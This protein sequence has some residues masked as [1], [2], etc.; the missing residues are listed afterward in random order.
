[1][2]KK[3]IDKVSRFGQHFMIDPDMIDTIVEFADIKDTE[4]VIE[5]GT[6]TGI[7]TEAIAKTGCALTSYEID[8]TLEEHHNHL[9]EKYKNITIVYE[10]ALKIELPEFD[11]IVANIPYNISEPLILKLSKC[12]FKEGILTVNKSFAE[13]M[14]NMERESSLLSLFTPA[15]FDV[16]FLEIVPKSSFEPRPRI[17][18]AIIN[19]KPIKKENISENDKRL[20]ITRNLFDQRTKKTENALL[21]A[22]IDYKTLVDKKRYTQNES[23]EF[24]N[25][26]EID[27]KTLEKKVIMLSYEELSTLLDKL[28]EK[29]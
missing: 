7:L 9:K 12:D 18:S 6:G 13:K 8:T 15:Y 28:E 5:I 27:D 19:I 14:L 1:M 10:N 25:T 20:F 11:K 24:L 2:N 29:L 21:E 22:I 16:E 23:R 4:T 3:Y 26:L 17:S